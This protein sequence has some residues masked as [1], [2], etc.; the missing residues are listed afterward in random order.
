VKSSEEE[1][2]ITP[3]CL[4]CGFQGDGDGNHLS[5]ARHR[6]ALAN[7]ATQVMAR[8]FCPWC[9]MKKLSACRNKSHVSHRKLAYDLAGDLEEFSE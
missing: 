6:R 4:I 2:K 3:C 7:M 8:G 9:K 1:I 5:G